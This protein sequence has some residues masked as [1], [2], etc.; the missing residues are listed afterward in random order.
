MKKIAVIASGWHYAS[1]F[2]QALSRQIIP[3]NVTVDLFVI[4]HRSPEHEDTIQEK[5]FIRNYI[6]NDYVKRFDS[7]LYRDIITKNDLKQLGWVYIEK[8]NTIGDMEVFNQWLEDYDYTNYDIFLITHDD[9]L[10][11]SN[12]IFVDIFDESIQLIKPIESSRYGESGH[13]FKTEIVNNKNDWMFLDN[14]YS[15]YIP[16]AFTPRGSFCFYTKEFIKMLPNNKFPMYGI[17]LNRLGQ[18]NSVEYSAIADWNTTA[19]NLRN[20]IYDNNLIQYV[21]WFSDTRRVS[22][23]CIEG[24]RGFIHKCN[25]H[26]RDQYIK[27]LNNMLK[28]IKYEDL[29]L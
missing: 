16:K 29:E 14:G 10:I 4:S 7:L 2:Y 25:N 28:N 19:G 11:L 6:D 1:Q 27:D 8:P 18:T 9:N 23:Y 13:Q 20:F 12:K 24:E 5:D 21:R 3:A 15:E 17:K 22:K 26:E